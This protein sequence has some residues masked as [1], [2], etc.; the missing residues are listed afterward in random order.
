MD[1]SS[2]ITIGRI[3]GIA[4]RIHWSWLLIF[5][6]LSWSLAEEMFGHHMSANWTASQRW[7]AGLATSALFFLS[8][9]LHELAHSFVAE[10]HGTR[11]PSITLFVFGGV[12]SMAEEMH[13]PGQ[14]FRVA[15]VGPLTSIVLAAVFAVLWLP[16]RHEGISVTFG[17][18][19]WINA[20][21]GVF[22]LLPGFPLDGGRVLR[23]IVWARTKSLLRATRVAS[24]VGTAMAYGLIALGLI[25]IIAF[26]LFGGLWYVLIGLFLKSASQGAYEAMVVDRALSDVR[27]GATMRPAPEPVDAGTN[28]QRLIDDR[29]LNTAERAFPV[30][31]EGRVAG[32]LT[33]TD[34]ARVSRERWKSTAVE[35][36]MIPVERVL[37]TTPESPLA[38]ALR[39]MQEHGFHQLPV[40]EDGRL[41]GMLTRGDVLRYV[42]VRTRFNEPEAVDS[43]GV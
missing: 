41:V 3:R 8:V 14:E 15:I 28:V 10:R 26:G 18:L 16:V 39:G 22:N 25:N 21:L 5:A 43:S 17:Y 34:I 27:V 32:L 2:S 1:F 40:L 35:A 6:L 11:V 12:S 37:T 7:A 24:Q 42:E 38:E 19:A 9:L 30:L 4:I 29:M 31:R 13:T 23:S 36:V 20:L 33:A